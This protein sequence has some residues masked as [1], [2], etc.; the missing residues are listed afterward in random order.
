MFTLGKGLNKS[1]LILLVALLSVFSV[2][3]ALK[4]L[5]SIDSTTTI[6]TD[7]GNLSTND[8]LGSA[9]YAAVLREA[10]HIRKSVTADGATNMVPIIGPKQD[11]CIRPYF[12]AYASIGLDVAALLVKGRDLRTALEY[13][14]L[15]EH[16]YSW[17]ATHMNPD[18]SIDD[19]TKGTVSNPESCGEADSED[20]YAG[21]FLHGA[22]VHYKA[23]QA[24]D[25]IGA[26]KF[27]RTMEPYLRRA[28]GLIITLQKPD[29]L[30]IAKK[31]YAIQYLMDNLEA[32]AGL[33]AV[34]QLGL[35]GFEQH[36]ERVAT[37][38]NRYLWLEEGHYAWGRDPQNGMTFAGWNNW[39]PD[40]LANAW[41]TYFNFIEVQKKTM[42]YRSLRQEFPDPESAFSRL[43]SE[44]IY[45]A[46]AALA[47]RDMQ[48]A[49]SYLR[50][51]LKHQDPQ[52]GFLDWYGYTHLSGWFIV[53]AASYLAWNEL[54][55]V[56]LV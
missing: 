27:L 47:Q 28:A 48:A 43:G 19:H 11:A 15:S 8:P 17:Y 24:I 52:G 14:R 9:L 32:Y 51:V 40:K 39:Y 34:R 54:A 42:I 37:A 56:F 1:L 30:T 5:I 10:E 46:M 49:E 2:E 22:Y 6:L 45:L 20:G 41:A 33:N 31:N 16:F 36:A 18:G 21:I 55:T 4:G 26:D 53:S 13:L 7:P 44:V 25:Q 35:P 29:G 12:A 3:P 23:T 38:I 50:E